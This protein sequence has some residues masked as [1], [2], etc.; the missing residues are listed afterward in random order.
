MQATAK[1]VATDL[2]NFNFL[3]RISQGCQ[4]V[5]R[6]VSQFFLLRHTIHHITSALYSVGRSVV[7]IRL[8]PTSRSC[9]V[10]CDDNFASKFRDFGFNHIASAGVDMESMTQECGFKINYA[11]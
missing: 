4:G 2:T 11:N 5:G 8:L 3:Q 10:C 1:T 7:L 6:G 9:G